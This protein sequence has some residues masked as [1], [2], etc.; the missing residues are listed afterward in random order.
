MNTVFYILGLAVIIAFAPLASIWAFNTLFPVLAI[1]Y[2]FETWL[3][4]CLLGMF[5]RGVK[6]ESK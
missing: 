2:T 1:P 3:A 4:T 6:T 5:V